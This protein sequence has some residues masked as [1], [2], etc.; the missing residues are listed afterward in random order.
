MSG[1]WN[2]F[3]IFWALKDLGSLMFPALSSLEA[4]VDVSQALVSFHSTFVVTLWDWNLDR[5]RSLLPL[6]LPLLA[7]HSGRLSLLSVTLSCLQNQ[8]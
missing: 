5:L 6:K 2:S 4:H 7:S 3:V 1:I 8:Y